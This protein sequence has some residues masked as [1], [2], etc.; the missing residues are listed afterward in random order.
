MDVVISAYL[1]PLLWSFYTTSME[2]EDMQP[3]R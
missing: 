2:P 1:T 3:A